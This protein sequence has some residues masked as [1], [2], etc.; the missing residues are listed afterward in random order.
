MH[1]KDELSLYHD[2]VA[3]VEQETNLRRVRIET[4][5]EASVT[6]ASIMNRLNLLH[7]ASDIGGVI[8]CLEKL[9]RYIKLHDLDNKVFVERHKRQDGDVFYYFA[10][11]EGSPLMFVN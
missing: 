4:L 10:D 5:A 7:L 1:Q 6:L 3:A 8:W 11:K 2:I 9:R